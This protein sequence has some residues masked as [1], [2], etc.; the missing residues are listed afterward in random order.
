MN[1]KF[2][3]RLPAVALLIALFCAAAVADNTPEPEQ[4]QP[5]EETPQPQPAEETPQPEQPQPVEEAPDTRPGPPTDRA[6]L[7]DYGA[8]I[9]LQVPSEVRAEIR[10]QA[11]AIT[12]MR[13]YFEQDRRGGDSGASLEFEGMVTEAPIIYAAFIGENSDRVLAYD[14]WLERQNHYVDLAFEIKTLPRRLRGFEVSIEHSHMQG[15]QEDVQARFEVNV[16]D[17]DADWEPL[18]LPGALPGI[19]RYRLMVTFT[20]REGQKTTHAGFSHWVLVNAPPT[21]TFGTEVSG[22]AS[23]LEV[24]GMT[25]L[26]AELAIETSFLLHHGLSPDAC[27]LRISRRGRRDMNLDPLPGNL[28][29]VVERDRPPSGWRDFGRCVLSDG[30]INGRQVVEVEDSFVTIRL[31]HALSATS[32]VLPLHEDWEYRFELRHRGKDDALAVWH[33]TVRVDINT[34]ADLEQAA[35]EV[36][37][38]GMEG[39]RHFHF[40]PHE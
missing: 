30:K 1:T 34:P 21:F 40:K 36:R 27:T 39:P 17:A 15:T 3:L 13:L 37:A 32:Q 16:P 33:V 22:E 4:P 26:Q 38:T 28:R 31:G 10:D 7:L 20:N 23:R 35:I 25:A 11:A 2:P 9:T 19:N 24:A 18:R 8:P 14:D 5:A 12:R 6:T 29:R